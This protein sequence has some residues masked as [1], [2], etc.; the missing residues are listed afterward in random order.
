MLVKTIFNMNLISKGNYHP[1]NLSCN[2]TV[3]KGQS[4]FRFI[5]S[6]LQKDCFVAVIGLSQVCIMWIINFLDFE[7]SEVV[8]GFC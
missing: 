5:L 4:S 7:I 6:P 1:R 8:L 3:R 2:N